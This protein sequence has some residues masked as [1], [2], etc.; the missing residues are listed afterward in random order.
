MSRRARWAAGL[1]LGALLLVAALVAILWLRSSGTV[2]ECET[3]P[4]RVDGVV[5]VMP[6][7]G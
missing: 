1:I 6:N 2:L 4:H 7:C 5:Y 3:T